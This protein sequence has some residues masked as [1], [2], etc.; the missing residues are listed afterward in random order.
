M[1]REFYHLLVK[2]S[3]GILTHLILLL[4]FSENR[5]KFYVGYTYSKRLLKKPGNI[6]KKLKFPSYNYDT[7]CFH[8]QTRIDNRSITQIIHDYKGYPTNWIR[9]WVIKED[10]LSLKYCRDHYVLEKL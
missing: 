7:G 10:N 9:A 4:D 5:A 2:H 1:D 6:V 8:Y 3:D